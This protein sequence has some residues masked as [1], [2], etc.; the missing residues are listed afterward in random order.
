MHYGIF[1]SIS[2]PMK[3]EHQPNVSTSKCQQNTDYTFFLQGP[4]TANPPL[5][6]VINEGQTSDKKPSKA[7]FLSSLTYLYIRN[8]LGCPGKWVIT[9]IWVFPK[10][11]VPQNGWFIM[12]NLIK[13]D[14]LGVPLFLE[15]SIYTV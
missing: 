13:M 7:R 8:V 9:P 10:I 4:K 1:S 5:P 14:D 11:G 15:T 2:V 12:E 6:K 3:I